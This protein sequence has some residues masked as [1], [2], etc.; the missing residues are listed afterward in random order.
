M[1]IEPDTF[2]GLLEE[3][4]LNVLC[5]ESTLLT[6]DCLKSYWKEDA[7]R[8]RYPQEIFLYARHDLTSYLTQYTQELS[9]LAAYLRNRHIGR[10]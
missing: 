3:F 9:H 8:E 2:D 4:R 5:F 10:R 7:L 6:L 1:T